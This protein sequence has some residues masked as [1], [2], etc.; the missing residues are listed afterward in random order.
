VAGHLADGLRS[1]GPLESSANVLALLVVTLIVSL[2]T[3]VFGELV[4]KTLAL[5]HAERY[6]LALARPVEILGAV[7]RPWSGS[8]PPSPMA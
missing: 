4:P 8:S 2:V 1:I 6:A 5:R 3:I 7:W